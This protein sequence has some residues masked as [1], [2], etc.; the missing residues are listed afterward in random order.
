MTRAT[1]PLDVWLKFDH[2][3]DNCDDCDVI[4]DGPASH[5]ANTYK[6]DD[7]SYRVEWYLNAVGL[8]KTQS[9]FTTYQDAVNWLLAEGFE[10]FSS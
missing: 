2:E 5:E 9:P 6:N 4:D 3:L 1:K 7:G 10:D 8:V